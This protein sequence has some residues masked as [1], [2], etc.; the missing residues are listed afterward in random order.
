MIDYLKFSVGPAAGTSGAA[1][2]E[3]FSQAVSGKVLAVQ[4]VP[5]GSPPAGTRLYLTGE[6]NPAERILDLTG[7]PART[8]YPHHIVERADGSVVT[9]DGGN[10]VTAPFAVHGRLRLQL[11]NT[12]PGVVVEIGV[13]VENS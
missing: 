11:T 9:Y 8:Y 10:P 7:V 6:T 13:W 5:G 2:A 1:A 3:A 12:N 4:T